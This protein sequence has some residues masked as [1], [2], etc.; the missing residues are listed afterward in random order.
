[1]NLAACGA[2]AFKQR[3]ATSYDAVSESFARFTARFSHPVAERMANLAALEAADQVLDVGTGTGVVALEAARR[4]GTR[5]SVRAIDL[6]AGMLATAERLAGRDAVG[7]QVVW[8]RMD[9]EALAFSTDHF[10]VV[11]SLFALL[12][13]PNPLVALREMLRVL[14]PGGRL[15]LAL[16]SRP[17]LATAAGLAHVL[18]LLPKLAR[19]RVG[20]EL[21]APG[22]LE[23]LVEKYLPATGADEESALAHHHHGRAESVQ[24][25]VRQAGFIEVAVDWGGYDHR[26]E[27]PEE[28]W[29]LQRTF[30]SLARKRIGEAS[31]A[32]ADA[33]Q[34]A[35]MATCQRVLSRGGKL[36]YPVG[37]LFISARK[38]APD[39]PHYGA[40]TLQTTRI[41]GEYN[42]NGE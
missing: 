33:L 40:T 18:Q 28:F 11:L 27:T 23:T 41:R 8:Q 6:S 15:I 34:G 13:F 19:R 36:V 2:E 14:K 9:A 1:M 12:H 3:D 4:V 39:S 22:F 20:R 30:S 21:A 31:Q 29:E 17:P 7:R 24:M 37:V 16:G 10:D 35:F 26:I 42:A 25:L 5:G 32:Q 38:L